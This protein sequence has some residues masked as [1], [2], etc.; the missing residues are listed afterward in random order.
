MIFRPGV[1]RKKTNVYGW[2]TTGMRAVY[3][4][5]WISVRED[6]II[7]PGGRRGIYGVVE[8]GPGVCIVPVTAIGQICLIRQY[9]YT[10]D[11]E[12]WELPAGA[13][14]PGEGEKACARRELFEE[15]GQ[16]ARALRRLGNF[17]TALGH[18][19]AEI[20]VYLATGLSSAGHSLENQELDESILEVRQLSPAAVR[21]MIRENRINCGISL[22]ALNLFFL[23]NQKI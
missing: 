16:R 15:I 6:R 10:I 19:T 8:K 18:E 23:H 5:P 3:K 7:Y 14:H 11:A 20:I 22:A 12:C 2:K 9:R 17:Y 13:I 21:K 1:R 4:N